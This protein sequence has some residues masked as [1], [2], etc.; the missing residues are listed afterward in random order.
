VVRDRPDAVPE[1]LHAGRVRD[2]LQDEP[3]HRRQRAAGADGAGHHQQGERGEGRRAR[4]K[5]NA[6]EPRTGWA[7]LIGRPPGIPAVAP[8][9]ASAAAHTDERL[10]RIGFLPRLLARPDIGALLGAIGVFLAFGY[11]P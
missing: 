8:T 3:E 2:A 6:L 9:T 7:V 1:G 11:F 10:V 4:R 5:G